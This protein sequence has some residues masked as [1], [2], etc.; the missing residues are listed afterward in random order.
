MQSVLSL[1][2]GIMGGF[3]LIFIFYTNSFLMRRRKREFGLYHV[4][5]MGKKNL[6]KV[7]AWECV[8]VSVVSLLLGI[9]T[10]ILFSKAAELVMVSLLNGEADF[11]FTISMQS[12]ALT[13]K[14]F[15]GIFLLILIKCLIQVSNSRPIELLK[16]EAVGEKPP[17]ANWLEGILGV[18]ILAGAYY[19][20]VSIEEPLAAMIWFFVAVAT[21]SYTHLYR[22]SLF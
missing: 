7:I 14:V 19:I 5:G 18:V 15:G 8:Q 1:G 10:G 21:V 20:A 2:C 13:L 12:L 6:A 9:F 11:G 4:L 16:S 3:A 22:W 17:K